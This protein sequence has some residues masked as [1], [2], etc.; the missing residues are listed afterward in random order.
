M[1]KQPLYFTEIGRKDNQEDSIFPAPG[2][3]TAADR[4]LM[5]CDG[6]GGHADGEVAS[7]CV[8]ETVGRITSQQ[9]DCTMEQMAETFDRALDE[10]YQE[11]DRLDAGESAK[12][13]GTTL[14]FLAFCQDGALVAHIGDSRVYQFRPGVGIVMQT[15]DHSLVND[16]VA[17]GEITEEEARTHPRRNVI[18]RAIMPCHG[19]DDCKCRASKRMVTDVMKGDIFLLCCDGVV[20]EVD[21]QELTEVM[22]SGKSLQEKLDTLKSLCADRDTRDNYTCY[23]VEMEDGYDFVETA[24]APQQVEIV[25]TGAAPYRAEAS[26]SSRARKSGVMTL[27]YVLIIVI[28]LLLTAFLVM[29]SCSDTHHD[30]WENAPLNGIIK[31]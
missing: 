7:R 11:M 12:K 1:I 10:A 23:L 14:T 31:R 24:Y 30:G 29:K 6:M 19:D 20:E 22:L 18:T 9:V 26:A 3:A 21:N 5:V 2:Q 16:L 25:A 4:V 15:R 8:A 28:S 27:I 17:A 13:M